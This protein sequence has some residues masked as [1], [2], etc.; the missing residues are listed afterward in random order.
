MPRSSE[1]IAALSTALAKAQGELINPEK[2]LTATIRVGRYGE[3]ERSFRYAPLSSGLVVVRKVLGRHE[4]ATVQTTE[5]D[6]ATGM[7]NLTTMLAHTSGEWIASDWPVCSVAE[8]ANPQR[9]GAALT[10]ARRYGLFTL[11][12]IAGEDDLDAPDTNVSK[13]RPA[14]TIGSTVPGDVGRDQSAP[15]AP[16]RRA[17]RSEP[18]RPIL[19]ANESGALRNTLNSEVDALSSA[20]QATDWARAALARK[21]ELTAADAK[22]V[23]DAF[24]QKLS[25]LGSGLV[26]AGGSQDQSTSEQHEDAGGGSARADTALLDQQTGIDKSVLTFPE[27]RRHRNREHLQFVARQGCLICGRKPS[28]AHHIRYAQP[29]AL[30]RKSSD[31]FTVPLCRIHHREVHRLGNERKFWRQVEIDPMPVAHRLWQKTLGLVQVAPLATPPAPANETPAIP[32]I[33]APAPND[34]TGEDAG[35][36]GPPQAGTACTGAQSISKT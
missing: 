7:V 25:Q 11:V 34:P 12:G 8:T 16:R 26:A 2:T 15:S 24:A 21:N 22:L 36:S 35:S 3:V 19:N 9:M 1:T 14:M 29:R 13:S 33:A 23:E 6:A 30:G 5:I 32:A 28:D 4:I 10:Y 17:A 27:P 18:M 20:D 31:E